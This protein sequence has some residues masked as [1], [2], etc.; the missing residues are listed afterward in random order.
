MQQRTYLRDER[1]GDGTAIYEPLQKLAELTFAH[2]RAYS[3]PVPSSQLHSE[4]DE[5]VI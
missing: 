2:R 1:N 5:S 3:I 4:Q